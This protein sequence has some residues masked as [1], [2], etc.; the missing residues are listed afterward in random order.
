MVVFQDYT[1]VVATQSYV[2]DQVAGLPPG[3][4]ATWRTVEV[5]LGSLPSNGGS[6]TVVPPGGGLTVGDMLFGFDAPGTLTTGEDDSRLEADAPTFRGVA[7][8]TTD[9]TVYW[10]SHSPMAGKRLLCYTVVSV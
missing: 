6:F 10:H 4:G 3:A 7:V 1:T 8:S 5:D 9:I 2:L